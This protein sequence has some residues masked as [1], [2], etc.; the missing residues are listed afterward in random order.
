MNWE[1]RY[2]DAMEAVTIS[3]AKRAALLMLPEYRETKRRGIARALVERTIEALRA[4]GIHKVAL[5]VFRRNEG[6]NAFWERMGFT[7]REDITYRNRT[8]DE[9]IRYDS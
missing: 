6:G 1:Q 3:P 5:V 2:R 9:M 8:L 4:L 7:V